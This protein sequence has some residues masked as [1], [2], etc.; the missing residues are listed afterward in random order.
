M[1]EVI[2]QTP[3][4]APRRRKKH[5]VLR[6]F[7]A[8]VVLVALVAVAVEIV[9]KTDL[10]RS[11]VIGQVE[12]QLGL[13][14]AAKTLSTG[15]MGHTELHEV[16]L[17]LPLVERAF[18][19]VPVM[20][21]KNSS[22][23]GLLLGRGISVQ[24][25][26]LDNP[27]VYVWQD[28]A[29]QWNLQQVIQLVARAGG[30][31]PAEESKNSGAPSLPKIKI[32]NATVVV[33]DNQ[34]RSLTVQ[35]IDVDGYSESAVS[36][37]YDVRVE[38]DSGGTPRL[39]VKG[40]VA[41][42]GFWAH[43]VGVQVHD[44]GDWIKP[45]DATPPA[46]AMDLQWSGQLNAGGIVGRLQCKKI[47]VAAA[48]VYGSLIVQTAGGNVRITP[49]NL[50]LKTGQHILPDLKLASG[51]IEYNGN[52]V[53]V[54][55]LMVDAFGGPARV[56]ANFNKNARK[57]SLSAMW[58]QLTVGPTVKHSGTFTA[59]AQWPLQNQIS[60]SAHLLASGTAPGGP[61]NADVH[62]G[63]NGSSPTDFDWTV[64]APTLTW[65]RAAELVLDSLHLTGGLHWKQ[66]PDS[67]NRAPVLT[68]ASATLG[69]SARLG[70]AGY[71]NLDPNEQDWNL[72]LDG[73]N[74]SVRPAGVQD[75]V[76]NLDSHGDKQIAFLDHLT[77]Q[78]AD[79][80]V[81]IDGTY[82]YGLPKPV[83]ATV[84]LSNVEPPTG[85]LLI[86]D[87]QPPQVLK[88]AL[89]GSTTLVGTLNPLL[90]EVIGQVKGHEVDIFQR[91]FGDIAVNLSGSV[92]SDRAD[93]RTDTLRLLDGDWNLEAQYML[94]TDAMDLILGVKNLSVKEVGTLA[95]RDDLGG[96]MSGQWHVYLP[97]LRF[98]KN[99]L[100]MHGD[101]TLDNVKAPGF[102]ADEIT[103]TTSL[104]N[105]QFTIN[106]IRMRRGEGRGELH[107]SVNLNDLRHYVAGAALTAWPIDVPGSVAHVDAWVDAPDVLVDLP[108]PKA[109]DPQQ[110]Q[111]NAYIHQLDVHGNVQ[112][113][114]KA[115]GSF[116]MYAG[117]W[118]R[119]VDV[120]GIHAELL[121][122]RADGQARVNLSD[123]TK[124][125][126][127]LTWENLDTA[128]FQT[129]MPAVKDLRGQ[130]TGTLRVAPAEVSHPLEPL[131]LVIENRF[132]GGSWRNTVPI[133]D[134]KIIGFIGQDPLVQEG[135]YRLV[136]GS[137]MNQTSYIHFDEGTLTFWGRVGRHS[138]DTIG[139]QAE[140]AFE[141][142]ELNTLVH[143]F[144]PTAH[145]MPGKL[146]GKFSFL[147]TTP[148]SDAPQLAAE[149]AARN[150]WPA[151]PTTAAT[152]A[153][154]T[155]ATNAPAT[156]PTTQPSALTRF[157]TPLYGDG[158]VQL[159][160]TNLAQFG[161]IA[162]LY[163]LMNIGQDLNVPTGKGNVGVHLEAGTLTVTEMRYF[164]RGVEVRAVA[165]V[166]DIGN[167]PD[168]PIS[169]SAVGTAVPMS[170]TKLPLLADVS[171]IMGAL[172]K[173]ILRSID[174]SGTVRDP[175]VRPIV[176]GDIGGDLKRM[177]VGDVRS[178]AA[179]AGR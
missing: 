55:Q 143:A 163:G 1:A 2:Q 83:R 38:P 60:A 86:S 77:F 140:L 124:T 89:S 19:N 54:E 103:A 43:E 75:L 136:L 164:N 129:F 61:F 17:G 23:F 135:G 178:G 167:I 27:T 121:G 145:Q 148:P 42:G 116:Q 39:G 139:I 44:I 45:W 170:N 149:R 65:H 14:V 56:D 26:E 13:R 100:V 62:F 21:V 111:L 160:R 24:A 104:Q 96:S 37:A 138:H 12:K 16:T 123:I 155:L 59:S 8:L 117:V 63:A 78:N 10:P 119:M 7:V 53:Q 32:A 107:A 115:L 18:V 113:L 152:T 20:K 120:R 50:L 165:R 144:E 101:A 87:Q 31:K 66:I 5:W 92:N 141:Q 47:A 157:L 46:I 35:P 68:L 130:M 6:I 93:V 57:A 177:I 28:E 58:S 40:R 82:T 122:G 64:D 74:W 52:D 79:A 91:H 158:E 69:G 98:E 174:I 137:G 162:F 147:F 3:P 33:T 156:A 179:G 153:P 131:A 22:L 51:R 106:P 169:G 176:F 133:Q 29:G 132:I 36:W 126:A 110:Q 97:A 15:W 48:E 134:A 73:R 94:Q 175:K 67:T 88:G 159:T 11:I 112:L 105:G 125:T 70:G 168:S 90:L 154:T 102:S 4:P 25:I 49:D 84:R 127:E 71:Y 114:N 72:H 41:P 142:L 76:F 108:D 171:D 118:G 151:H 161:P 146:A 173:T 166:D 81:T 30:Q 80:T 150:S 128:Q 95:G 99:A 172:E 109:R 34:K 9:F 85:A